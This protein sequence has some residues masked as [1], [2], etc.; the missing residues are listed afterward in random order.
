MRF[1]VEVLLLDCSN[2]LSDIKKT[3]CIYVLI[4]VTQNRKNNV[5][6]EKVSYV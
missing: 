6:K 1:T 2:F 5:G 4:H 3:Y